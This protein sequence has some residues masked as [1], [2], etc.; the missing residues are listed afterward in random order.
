MVNLRAISAQRAPKPLAGHPPKWRRE[1][2]RRPRRC[3]PAAMARGQFIH[4]NRWVRAAAALGP[5]VIEEAT[6]TSYIPAR[7]ALRGQR[8]RPYRCHAR[9]GGVRHVRQQGTDRSRGARYRP[10]HRAGSR[11]MLPDGVEV[12]PP[13]SSTPTRSRPTRWRKRAAASIW[14]SEA[15]CRPAESHS[16]VV[17]QRQLL[18][19]QGRNDALLEEL[20]A[21]SGGIPV[22]TASSA[23]VAALRALGSRSARRSAPPIRRR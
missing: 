23:L 8:V 12:M 5:V 18:Q 19:W 15:W 17:H 20:A 14:R 9:L 3:S 21:F 4:V 6:A 10:L 22:A 2:G 13:A 11:R 16:L 1:T 7:L